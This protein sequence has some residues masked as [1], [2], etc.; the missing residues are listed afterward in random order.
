M[1][2][3]LKVSH[4]QFSSSG[5]KA[6][7]QDSCDCT[8]PPSPQLDIKGAVSVIADGISTSDVSQVASKT[9]VKN[10]LNDYYCTSEAWSV[11]T[12]G[13]RV[14][15]SING[16]LAVQT[17]N[18]DF[19]FNKDKGY[20]C[21]FSAAIF[22][23]FT[24]HFFHVGDSRIYR[25]RNNLLE[26][27]TKDHRTW[28]SSQTS[29]LSRALGVNE[30]LEIDYQSAPMQT[31]DIYIL[32][33]DGVYEFWD[34][35]SVLALLAEHPADLD[36]TAKLLAS[37]ALDNGSA[38][39]LT[40]QLVRIDAL[41][42]SEI[43]VLNEKLNNLA[44]PPLL[45]PRQEFDGYLIL[46][47]LHANSRSHVYLAK[48][49]E[50]E[51]QVA[52]KIPSIARRQDKSYLEC[53]VME[54]WVARRI[55]NAHVMKAGIQRRERK[56]L[57]TVTEFIE[58][59]SLSQWLTDTP[60][61]DLETVRKL[62]EQVAKGLHGIHR[63]EILHQDLRPDNIMID[64]NG[65]VK[66]IDF[67]AVRISGIEELKKMSVESE[68]PG[69]ALFMAPEFFVGEASSTRSDQYSLAV[70]TYYMLSG[71]FPYG[72]AIVRANSKAAQRRLV[73]QS[74]LDDKRDIPAWINETLRKALQISPDRRYDEISEFIHDLRQPNPIYLRKS[75][76]PLIERNPLGFWKG[77][78][79]ISTTIAITLFI[80]IKT[81]MI[82]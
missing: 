54:E 47:E 20:V 58:G 13:K 39:N 71:R 6:I 60:K 15:E 24:A 2:N 70:I 7:N 26:Q 63:M 50:N 22:K 16:W 53:L 61:L 75:K 35:D 80:Y 40:I 72:N 52:L 74:V 14:I 25:F 76:A 21:T 28:A 69:D 79:L 27:L 42:K 8:I 51:S 19:R 4:G 67:G 77:L 45:K 44:L 41:P 82:F 3:S 73:Y 46:R 29:Y 32:C 56:F 57:Y 48:D 17:L 9:A 81:H 36:A 12:S 23:T 37:Q 59:I 34:A 33:T 31:D 1:H 64:T 65:T 68:L 78:A 43:S 11:Q 66:I 10:F 18:S 55:N 5:K 38:D 49:L 62:I 30:S